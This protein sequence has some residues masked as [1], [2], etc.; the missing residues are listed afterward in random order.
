[1]KSYVVSKRMFALTSKAFRATLQLR[2]HEVPILQRWATM[3]CALHVCFVSERG[4]TVLVALRAAPQSSASFGRTI[5]NALRRRGVSTTGLRGHWLTCITETE[6][7]S[8][9]IGKGTAELALPNT[10]HRADE[11]RCNHPSPSRTADDA[12]VVELCR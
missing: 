9:C 7:I 6:A 4:T 1:M 12:R 11:Q 10:P 2:D 5:R 3:N 8:V